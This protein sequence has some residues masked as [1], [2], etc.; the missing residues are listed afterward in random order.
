MSPPHPGE[1]SQGQGTSLGEQQTLIRELC[2]Q[3]KAQAGGGRAWEGRGGEAKLMACKHPRWLQD[4]A[5]SR[6]SAMQPE[7]TRPSA[8]RQSTGR[9]TGR[10]WGTQTCMVVAPLQALAA[11]GGR[12]PRAPCQ[13]QL[14]ILLNTSS[15][16]CRWVACDLPYRGET[17]AAGAAARHGRGGTAF[18]LKAVEAPRGHRAAR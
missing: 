6:S 16:G 15:L 1:E 12:H 11:S 2:R 4:K 5:C 13:L 18:F 8:R 3:Q 17:E 7:M 9:D 10:C 14:H